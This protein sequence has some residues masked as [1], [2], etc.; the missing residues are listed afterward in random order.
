M[1]TSASNPT[2][3]YLDDFSLISAGQGTTMRDLIAIPLRQTTLDATPE[4]A[5]H[6]AKTPK[7][8]RTREPAVK[9]TKKVAATTGNGDG[10]ELRELK[11]A[12]MVLKSAL[13][14]K[15]V[16]SKN[17]MPASLTPAS[18]GL[19][20]K[21]PAEKS[22]NDK[23]APKKSKPNR[24][25]RSKQPMPKSVDEFSEADRLLCDLRDEGKSWDEITVKYMKCLGITKPGKDVIRKR[26]GKL[27]RIGKEWSE[28]DVEVEIIKEK[29]TRIAAR[30]NEY[31][32]NYKP[33]AC[34]KMYAGLEKEG[35]IDA[36]GD[37]LNKGPSTN[38]TANKS[39]EE[40]A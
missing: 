34:E 16:T 27:I 37:Y 7:Q 35:L 38:R 28:D 3:S 2:A 13:K 5:A 32:M 24:G 19:T 36:N 23:R 22:S 9:P 40:A 8:K 17:A 1:S 33:R 12:T 6:K 31:N 39:D 25:A 26:Y 4:E 21:R 20:K 15:G 11:S 10:V 29:W 30:L 14:K 18:K